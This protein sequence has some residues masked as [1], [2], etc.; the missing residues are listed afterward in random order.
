MTYRLYHAVQGSTRNHLHNGAP[1]V[2]GALVP[3]RCKQSGHNGTRDM[4][5]S[6][7]E[8]S[9]GGAAPLLRREQHPNAALANAARCLSAAVVGCQLCARQVGAPQYPQHHLQSA[10]CL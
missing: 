3:T 6:T 7:C 10:P 8:G 9:H 2:P 5:S 4:Q 1:N